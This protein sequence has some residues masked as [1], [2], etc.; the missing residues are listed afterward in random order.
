LF[1][2]TVTDHIQ[3]QTVSLGP[4]FLLFIVQLVVETAY[5]TLYNGW[6]VLGV[7]VLPHDLVMF[8]NAIRVGLY[9]LF[10]GRF[11]VLAAKT[12]K[13]TDPTEHFKL[14]VYVF[15]F[16]VVILANLSDRLL[17]RINIFRV[18]SALF[19]LHFSSLFAFVLFMTFSHWAYD[20]EIDE[21]YGNA[22]V[23]IDPRAHDLLDPDDHNQEE[24]IES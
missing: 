18:T 16:T 20:Y 7:E 17:T 1:V 5:P 11:I 15:V 24:N 22:E 4:K 8:V 2:L 13:T 19:T 21:L 14:F 6:E 12:W 3:G 10:V 23:E 9:V